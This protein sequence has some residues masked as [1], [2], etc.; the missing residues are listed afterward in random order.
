[1]LTAGRLAGAAPAAA[2][3]GSAEAALRQVGAPLKA[4]IP[5]TKE[6]M[7]FA[8][9]ANKDS[10]IPLSDESISQ[11]L[12][13]IRHLFGWRDDLLCI[14]RSMLAG[15]HINTMMG[16]GTTATSDAFVAGVATIIGRDA[17]GT[18][19]LIGPG[20]RW[21]AVAVVKNERGEL[22]ALDPLLSDVP[23]PLDEL[24]AALGAVPGTVTIRSPLAT[25]AAAEAQGL[26]AHVDDWTERLVDS[27]KAG[28]APLP[29]NFWRHDGAAADI[30]PLFASRGAITAMPEDASA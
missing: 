21:H 26:P 10:L 25:I 18:R 27:L 2:A 8:V 23:M 22:L 17:D 5:T 15:H 13:A 29:S 19:R 12:A 28:S 14:P 7:D 11:A 4:A 9:R 6:S 30:K 1:M 24:V 20:W 3:G 16:K